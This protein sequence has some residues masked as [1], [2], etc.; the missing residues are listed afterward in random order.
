MDFEEEALEDIELIS[1]M[2]SL[3]GVLLRVPPQPLTVYHKTIG[4][5]VATTISPNDP[6]VV[7]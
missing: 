3:R 4:F 1:V 2:L 6:P 7:R 5:D